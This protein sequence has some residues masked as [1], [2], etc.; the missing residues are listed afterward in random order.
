MTPVSALFDLNTTM[1][2]QQP[3]TK[4]TLNHTYREI[5]ESADRFVVVIIS[6]WLR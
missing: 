1:Q 6:G 5:K 2:Q 4:A 3:V